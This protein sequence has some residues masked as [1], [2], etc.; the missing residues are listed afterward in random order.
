MK[1]EPTDALKALQ[2]YDNM[3]TGCVHVDVELRP[4]VITAFKEGQSSPKIKQ[5]EWEYGLY[6]TLKSKTLI[7]DYGISPMRDGYY[8]YLCSKNKYYWLKDYVSTIDEAKSAAQEDFENRV[9]Q[10]LEL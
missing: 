10:C 5:L 8:M 4:I 2:H 7:G 1:T 6:N 3:D 9:K